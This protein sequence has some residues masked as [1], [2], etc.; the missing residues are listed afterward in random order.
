MLNTKLSEK[1]LYIIEIIR[2]RCRSRNFNSVAVLVLKVSLY[3]SN[4][5]IIKCNN[6]NKINKSLIMAYIRPL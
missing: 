1:I 5:C 6:E 4:V 2:L 3:T